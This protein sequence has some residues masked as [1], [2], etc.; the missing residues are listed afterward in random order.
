MAK[1]SPIHGLGAGREAVIADA[2]LPPEIDEGQGPT[3]NGS[4][5]RIRRRGAALLTLGRRNEARRAFAQSLKI[6]PKL[7]EGHR[8]LGEVELDAGN[9]KEAI[10]SL[11]EAEGC[12][13][14]SAG[15]YRALRV[16]YEAEDDISGLR[17]SGRKLVGAI[18]SELTNEEEAETFDADQAISDL[19]DDFLG[20]MARFPP[21]HGFDP[22]QFWV[23]VMGSLSLPQAEK[24][25]IIEAAASERSKEGQFR[26]LE[27]YFDDER[28]KWHEFLGPESTDL[29]D[30]LAAGGGGCRRSN[31]YSRGLHHSS[32]D[33]GRA[34]MAGLA[35]TERLRAR[36]RRGGSGR[37]CHLCA[38]AARTGRGSRLVF[39][40]DGG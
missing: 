33:S 12:G 3:V 22:E 6:A 14:R 34:Y 4:T 18:L 15:L 26:A 8:G 10:A 39:S 23:G 25:R 17:V 13:D 35:G 16:A 5:E 28:T 38:G 30:W 40:G 1:R 19:R 32:A 29:M 37:R 31:S 36:R 24:Y 20:H 2:T 9:G 7:S 27:R 21:Y 11:L